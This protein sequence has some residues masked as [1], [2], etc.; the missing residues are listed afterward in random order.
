MTVRRDNAT[1]LF[2][3]PTAPWKS[4]D[5]WTKW[6]VE[7][8]ASKTRSHAPLKL[9]FYRVS[10]DGFFR[11]VGDLELC[12]PPL[13]PDL[14]AD[15]WLETVFPAEPWPLALHNLRPDVIVRD[16]TA[17]KASLI[18]VKTRC[19]SVQRNVENYERVVEF[20]VDNDW[21][22]RLFYLLSAGHEDGPRGDW[23]LLERMRSRIILWEDVLAAAIG[24]EDYEIKTDLKYRD[25]LNY[26]VKKS[27]PG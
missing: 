4:E 3:S 10:A 22:A 11:K 8:V 24:S 2:E 1:W 25:C 18:E 26:L 21:N 6:F 27:T 15:R 5:E 16:E 20:L 17:R 12:R 7:L 23:E 14:K 13:R 9:P 19:A